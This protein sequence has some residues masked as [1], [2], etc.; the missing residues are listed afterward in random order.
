[1]LKIAR[2]FNAGKRV[3]KT[4]VPKG[5]PN[6][7]EKEALIFNRPFGTYRLFASNPALK[8]WAIVACPFGT[9]FFENLG[10]AA[11]SL[12]RDFIFKNDALF[13]C[14]ALACS[15]CLL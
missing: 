2:R 12:Y 3:G 4:K 10:G 1:M 9:D 5:R 11:T 8:R 7:A 14:H 6:Q 15:S 13:Y